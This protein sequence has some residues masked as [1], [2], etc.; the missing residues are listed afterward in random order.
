[1]YSLLA[2]VLCF[3][4][5][6]TLGINLPKQAHDD[7]PTAR[8]STSKKRDPYKDSTWNR[9]GKTERAVTDVALTRLKWCDGI[10]QRGGRHLGTGKV[11]GRR[12]DDAAGLKQSG[13][14]DLQS[15]RQAADWALSTPAVEPGGRTVRHKRPRSRREDGHTLA[16]SSLPWALATDRRQGAE[17][18]ARRG[19]RFGGPGNPSQDAQE[20]K[21]S[22][23][24]YDHLLPHFL[25]LK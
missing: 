12:E 5:I 20:V 2:A 7:T 10:S 4:T 17:R 3:C 18:V 8:G 21:S 23:S 16:F 9:H 11:K 19:V 22:G 15:S 1:M 25:H 6:S 24:D 13:P 14:G